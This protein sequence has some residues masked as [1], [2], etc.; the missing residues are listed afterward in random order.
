MASEDELLELCD[1]VGG[2]EGT[3]LEAII[4]GCL[5]GFTD[6]E[7]ELLAQMSARPTGPSTGTSSASPP[8]D[9]EQIEHQ[10]LP[11]SGPGRW[12]GG[13]SP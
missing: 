4:E 11:S 10:L 8:A 7:I 1:V 12:A 3:T 6:A 9:A 13:W 5:K 2:H